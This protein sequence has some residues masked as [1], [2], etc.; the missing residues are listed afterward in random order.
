M[1]VLL[2]NPV[3]RESDI[4]KYFPLGPGLIG[5][6][7]KLEGHD[8]EALDLNVLRWPRR[9]TEKFIEKSDAELFALTGLITDY[10]Q[11]KD[12]AG[13][14]K[15]RHEA[16]KII[17]GGGLASSF[18][19]HVLET[20]DVDYV[21]PGEGEIA[22]TQLMNALAAGEAIT[23]I[24]GVAGKA[25][26]KALPMNAPGVV[27]NL[28][29]PPRTDYDLFPWETYAQN[30]KK[31]WMFSRPTK[32]LSVITSRGCP[33]H[34]IYC[35]K[36]IFGNRFRQR[37]V[38]HVIDEIEAMVGRYEL[39]G[40]LFADDTFTLRKKWVLEFCREFGRR[41]P[42]VRWTC[43]GRVNLLDGETV[44]AMAAAGCDTVGFG[45]ES[46]SQA[47]LDE[48]RKGVTVEKAKETVRLVESC[49]IRPLGYITLGSF[50]EKPETVGETISFLKETGLVA[51]VN[52]LTPFPGTPLFD[53]AAA[54]GKVTDRPEELLGKWDAWQDKLLVN[55]TDLTDEELIRLKKKVQMHAGGRRA[56]PAS[57]AFTLS[58]EQQEE[59]WEKA[60][61]RMAAEGHEKFILFGAGK[62]SERF[63]KWFAARQNPG[64][65]FVFDQDVKKVSRKTFMGAA[66]SDRLPEGG[67]GP[68]I[69]I[70]SDA[71]EDEMFRKLLE[72]GQSPEGIYRIYADLS[73]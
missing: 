56:S 13:I 10:N 63:I 18:W 35:D 64:L 59:L 58:A 3:T 14:I 70:S 20:T 7:L 33:Y 29:G 1:R 17:L 38:R 71:Y 57:M 4:P 28:D 9:R 22:L 72:L 26:G 45:I 5:A 50:S 40:V 53:E 27:E 36:A 48:L 49:G 12:L 24:R 62:H 25:G 39:D 66:I 68:A 15:K 23:G 43:N 47:I 51:G 73:A 11:V 42:R 55:L 31:A 41:L 30:M 2:I 21:L 34:C 19:R 52:F 61:S 8:V 69:L 44:S 60:L 54:R 37:S 32:A 46:G 65:D 67:D 6:Q 16:R